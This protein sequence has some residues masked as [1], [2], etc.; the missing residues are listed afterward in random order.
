M[1]PQLETAIRDWVKSSEGWMEPERAV[2]MAQLVLDIQPEI[3]VEIGV[4]GGRS[5]ISQAL[6][7]KANGHGKI[8]GIDAWKTEVAIEGENDSN[9]KW[10]KENIDINQIHLYAFNGIWRYHLQEQAILLRAPS[11]YCA[12]MFP[13]I[14]IIFIDGCHS[15]VA[16]CRDVELFVPKVRRAGHIWFDDCDWPTTQKAQRLLE[17]KCDT[18]KTS[19]D[20]HYKLFKKR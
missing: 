3:V 8:Y 10:W 17:E 19:A 13:V 4:F 16:S 14:D 20:G 6:A 11:Q 9:A 12:D 7:L 1:T 5:L 15:E 2:E 18:V